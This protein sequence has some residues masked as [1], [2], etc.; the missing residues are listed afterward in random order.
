MGLD[1]KIVS[2]QAWLS[3]LESTELDSS[4]NPSIKLLDFWRT[5]VGVSAQAMDLAKILFLQYGTTGK[6]VDRPVSSV[7]AYEASSLLKQSCAPD[8]GLIR[9]IVTAWRMSG[10]L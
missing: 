7:D 1:F 9:K 2:P 10:F 5:A 6:A 4:K 8:K 3:A